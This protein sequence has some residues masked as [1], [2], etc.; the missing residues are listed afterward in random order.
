M[1]LAHFRLDVI[2]EWTWRES[3]WT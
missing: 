3:S 1:K 2:I